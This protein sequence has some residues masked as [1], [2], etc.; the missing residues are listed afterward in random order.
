MKEHL[1]MMF[2][3]FSIDL[4]NYIKLKF[5]LNRLY[6]DSPYS[7]NFISRM[8]LTNNIGRNIN[9]VYL[10]LRIRLSDLDLK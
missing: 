7:M 9:D 1:I 10:H 6:V 2:M 4:V 5:K 8:M 3:I